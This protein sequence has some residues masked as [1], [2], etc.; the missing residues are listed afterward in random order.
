MNTE[1][2]KSYDIRG[3]YPKEINEDSIYKIGQAYVKIIKPQGKVVVSRDVRIHSESLVKALINGLTDAGMDVVDIGLV[4]TEMLYFAVANYGFAGGL[5]VT[6]SH[7]PAEYNGLKLVREEAKPVFSDNGLYEIRDLIVAGK[8]K[9]ESELKGTLEQKDVLED[10]SKFS[11]DFI[12]S[13]TIKPLKLVYNPN[14]G[15]EAEVLKKVV[16]IGSLPLTLA[17][18][19]DKPDGTFPKGRPDPFRPENRPEF[20]E[21]VKSEQADLGVAW[22]ADADRVFFCTKE[23]VFVEPY[24]MSA[25]LI[26]IILAKNPGAKIVYD[27]RYT[28]ALI[29]SAKVNGGEAVISR[30][31]HSFIKEK[32]REVDAV[33]CGESSGHI[34]FKNFWYADSGMIPLLLVLELI[35]KGGDLDD[36][37]KPYFEKY[38]ISGEINN[39]VENG[40][41]KIAF[42]K[43][44]YAD[45]KISELDGLSVEYNRDWR[46]NV[47]PSNT[48]PLLRLNVEAKNKELMEEKRDE[49]LKI[50]RA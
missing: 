31:G 9:I 1:I 33:F 3:V 43:E 44:R 5:Q 46:F 22:D 26:K 8:E 50:I 32:M 27:P 28:W 6:A 4:S 48:E 41:E 16:E 13:Q 39:E 42:L 24:F 7:L 20:I 35:S 2:F 25:L 19:N 45:G 29:D 10:F 34:Y 38:F 49:L 15:F 17:G 37:L 36:L 30:V 47:R 11:L 21:K 40:E 18:L 23:G 14:F 12:D